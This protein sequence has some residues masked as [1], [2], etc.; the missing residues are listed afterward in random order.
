[1]LNRLKLWVLYS[2]SGY[3][4]SISIRNRSH[5]LTN[6]EPFSTETEDKWILPAIK[7]IISLCLTKVTRAFWE[8]S[9]Y[10]T[11]RF[12]MIIVKASSLLHLVFHRTR[13]AALTASH[14]LHLQVF[15]CTFYI[16][17][18]LPIHSPSFLPQYCKQWK[19]VIMLSQNKGLSLKLLEVPTHRKF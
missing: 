12:S 17:P 6:S 7:R 3:I 14:P 10:K 9:L 11:V 19:C 13:R 2:C 5:V 8:K 4:K 18:V 1:M 15:H 16:L